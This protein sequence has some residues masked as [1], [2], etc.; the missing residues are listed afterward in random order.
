MGVLNP[1]KEEGH[2]MIITRYG[3]GKV[4]EFLTQ[5]IAAVK[6]SGVPV[7]W[8][9]DAAHG[10]GIVAKSNKLKTRDAGDILSELLKCIAVHKRCGCI[11]GG[12]HLEMSGQEGIT[13]CLGG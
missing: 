6:A 1:N 10:N 11:L 4:E 8:Q 12:L 9:C 5:H 3:A 2:L 7:V 13:E